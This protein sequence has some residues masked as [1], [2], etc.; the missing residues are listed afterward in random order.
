MTYK[1]YNDLIN[2]YYEIILT[3]SLV[4]ISV[5]TELPI[6]FLFLLKDNVKREV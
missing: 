2:I 5:H 4:N 1:Q 3:V 6:L